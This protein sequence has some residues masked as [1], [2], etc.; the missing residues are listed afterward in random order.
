MTLPGLYSLNAKRRLPLEV[1][2]ARL[3]ADLRSD[4]KLHLAFPG[5]TDVTYPELAEA[6]SSHQINNVG[7]SYDDGHGRNHTKAYEREVIDWFATLFGAGKKA[8]GYV[9]PGATEGTIHALDEAATAYPN[10]VVYASQDAHYSVA[11]AARLVRATLV[12][13]YTDRHGRMSLDHLRE[14]LLLRRD[15][16]AAIVATVGT[17]ERE[18]VDDVAGIAGLC[19]DLNITR[20]RLHV[21]AALAGIPR[22]LLPPDQRSEF[23]FT[24]GATSMV[25]SGHKFLSTLM[26]CGVLVYP[27]RPQPAADAEVAYIGSTDTTI[28]GSRSGHTPL[29]LHW[30]LSLGIDH[31][32]R[33]AEDARELAAYT[34]E[35]LQQ[36]GWPSIWQMPA[37]TINLAQPPRLRQPWVLGGD[38]RGGRIICMPGIQRDW[39]DEFLDDLTAVTL[40][41]T[42]VAA[43]RLRTSDQEAT[44]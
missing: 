28:S 14:Q 1:H 12:Q 18:A 13:V 3:I 44:A 30:S 25:V 15:R 11:K 34:Y 5:G 21:D 32:R 33:R 40:G 23:G 26:P 39:I 2:A 19:D 10:L 9:T 42:V 27:H 37:F 29:L 41:R 43:P 17:T 20:R 24:A 22:V 31:H 36:L 6:L 35:R 38:R 7:D 4:R 8:W 16:P